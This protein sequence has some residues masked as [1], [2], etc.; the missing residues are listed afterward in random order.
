MFMTKIMHFTLV[1]FFP[2]SVPDSRHAPFSTHKTHVY[3]PIMYEDDVTS[4]SVLVL[5]I[6]DILSICVM[7]YI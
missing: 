1:L 3:I 7:E 4:E 6:R 5:R 2:C